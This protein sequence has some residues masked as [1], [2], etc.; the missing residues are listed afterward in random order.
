[1][2]ERAQRVPEPSGARQLR[3]VIG[4]FYVGLIMIFFAA[5][6]AGRA[7]G[8]A[9]VAAVAPTPT[10]LPSLAGITNGARW[11]D[12]HG[13]FTVVLPKGWRMTTSGGI[14][15]EG[16]RMGSATF[17]FYDI[18]FAPPASDH[19]HRGDAFAISEYPLLNAFMRQW[20]C[21]AGFKPNTKLAGLPAARLDGQDVWM[22]D[23]YNAHYQIDVFFDGATIVNPG[24]P[25][26]P[27]APPT[28]TPAPPGYAQ[29]NQS[30]ML[31]V[32]ASFAPT[33]AKALAC[34]A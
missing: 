33:P 12:P 11:R 6:L 26:L 9:T 24:G 31:R 7:G 25:N 34:G 2:G 18:H 14:S 5:L 3:V 28:P 1:M 21:R 30:L 16:N 17:P 22:L 27:A 19:A 32:L 20:Q 23:T 4:V 15:T 10:A 8:A 13:L 29:A